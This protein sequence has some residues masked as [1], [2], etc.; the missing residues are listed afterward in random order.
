MEQGINLLHQAFTIFLFCIAVTILFFTYHSYNSALYSVKPNKK[1]EI[2]YEQYNNQ[3]EITVTKGK[4]ISMLLNNPLVYDMEVDGIL[5][6][7]MEN[8]RENIITY[9]FEHDKYT[10]S[11]AYDSKGNITR[12][13]FKGL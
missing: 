3:K 5:I 12:I 11:Y 2:M 6:S 7:K 9:H 13:I 4:I 10:K 1:V 8:T